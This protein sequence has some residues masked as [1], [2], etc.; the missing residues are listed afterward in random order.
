VRRCRRGHNLYELDHRSPPPL[1]PS[2][3]PR[4]L[5]HTSAT[6]ATTRPSNATNARTQKN[7]YYS[8][9]SQPHARTRANALVTG[10]TNVRARAHALPGGWRWLALVTACA[11]VGALT[12]ERTNERTGDRAVSPRHC[13]RHCRTG[14]C[15]A[16]CCAA[17][18]W[19]HVWL[20]HRLATV[21]SAPNRPDTVFANYD[22]GTLAT[23][24]LE[25]CT[26]PQ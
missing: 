9:G 6:T 23:R 13:V 25:R 2:H 17:A 15:A 20:T 11:L 26:A 3:S 1:P 22:V 12:N 21:G 16:L 24:Y 18:R 19:A 8:C 5:A 7:Y 10:D 14:R 4:G